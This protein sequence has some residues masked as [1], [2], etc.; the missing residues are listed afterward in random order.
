M[1]DLERETVRGVATC[2]RW[3]DGRKPLTRAEQGILA[4][5]LMGEH[6]SSIYNTCECLEIAGPV[7][8]LALERAIQIAL[9]ENETF[10]ARFVDVG[11]GARIWT[12]DEKQPHVECVDIA[13]GEDPWQYV[14]SRVE[15][16]LSSRVDLMENALPVQY[17]YRDGSGHVYWPINMHHIILDGYSYTLLTKRVAQ[18]YNYLV[19]GG[20]YPHNWT[21]TRDALYEE[22]QSY[23]DSE[24][25]AEDQCY[26]SAELSGIDEGAVSPKDDIG[27]ASAYSREL[28]SFEGEQAEL[29]QKISQQYGVSAIEALVAAVVYVVHQIEASRDT[30]IGV[31]T[32]GRAGSRA[33]RAYGTSSNVLPLRVR[34]DME[35]SVGGFL[36]KVREKIDGLRRHQRHRIEDVLMNLGIS[37]VDQ[38]LYRTTVNVVPFGH[39]IELAGCS[40]KVH[41]ISGG[42]SEALLCN[43]RKSADGFFV[44][45]D[46][47]E[48]R[49]AAKSFA[50]RLERVIAQFASC[51]PDEMLTK[52]S[53]LTRQEDEA[54][55]RPDVLADWDDESLTI[56]KAFENVVKERQD[57]VAVVDG[58]LSYTYLEIDERADRVARS[59]TEMGVRPGDLVG[60]ITER[61]A[62][63]VV[64]MLAIMKCSATYLPIDPRYPLTRV[65]DILDDAGSKA[66]V[67]DGV[68]HTRQLAEDAAARL[69]AS[70]VVDMSR[71]AQDRADVGLDG[72]SAARS[73]DIA[74]VLYTSG[75]TGKP[76]G[77]RITHKNV[78]SLL[79]SC[80]EVL[81]VGKDDV[82]TV[83]HSYSFDFSTWEIWGSL[84]TRGR[85]VVV[86]TGDSVDPNNFAQL[87]RREQ[88]TVLSQTPTA[89]SQLARA[90]SGADLRSVRVV[91]FGGEA[92]NP[93]ALTKAVSHLDGFDPV[94]ANMYGITETTVHTTLKVLRVNQLDGFAAH[95]NGSPIG[96]ELPGMGIFVLDGRR[97]PRPF[98][99]VGEFY[100]V[101]TGVADGYVNRAALTREKFLDL[102]VGGRTL[103]AYRTGDLGS[104]EA[105][106]ELYYYGRSDNQVKIRGHRIETAEVATA[107]M[108]HPDVREAWV[109]A[110][111]P[112]SEERG[113]TTVLVGYFISAR[114]G[115][116]TKEVL[117]FLAETLPAYMIPAFL[118]EIDGVPLTANNKLD[119]K[120]LPD[121]WATF[122]AGVTSSQGAVDREETD[123]WLRMLISNFEEVLHL[124]AGSVNA[125]GNFFEL[126]GHSILAATLL[127]RIRKSVEES[128]AQVSLGVS[129]IFRNPTPR[130]L[131]SRLRFAEI[132]ADALTRAEAKG[133]PD[134]TQ[135]GEAMKP[136]T[137]ALSFEQ[138]GMWFLHKSN[139]Q[140]TAY[141]IGFSVSLPEDVDAVLVA[142]ALQLTVDRHESLRTTYQ[143][144]SRGVWQRVH[145]PGERKVAVPVEDVSPDEFDSAVKKGLARTFDLRADLPIAARIVRALGR[146]QAF[147]FVIHHIAIDGWSLSLF[148][149]DLSLAY[150]KLRDGVEVDWPAVT[151]HYSDYC[152]LVN[153]ERRSLTLLGG[154]DDSPEKYWKER[155]RA[156]PAEVSTHGAEHRRGS[157]GGSNAAMLEQEMPS[158]VFD[159]VRDAARHSNVTEFSVLHAALALTLH[160]A[161]F[162]VDIVI[163]TPVSA[164]TSKELEATVGM[165]A[166]SVPLRTQIRSNFTLADFLHEVWDSDVA[167]IRYQE[168]PFAKIVD[169]INPPR[170]LG[171]HPIFQIMLSLQ[172][173]QPA[174]L[175]LGSRSHNLVPAMNKASKFDLFF[176]VVPPEG[177]E[178]GRVRVEFDTRL[179]GEEFVSTLLTRFFAALRV[180]RFSLGE[181][182]GAA[183]ERLATEFALPPCRERSAAEETRERISALNSVGECFARLMSDGPRPVVHAYY[184]PVREGAITAVSAVVAE[185]SGAY[186]IVP[187]AVSSIPRM[188][189]GEVDEAT[190]AAIAGD[191]ED[192]IRSW[193][194]ELRALPGVLAVSVDREYA[195]QVS[196]PLEIDMNEVAKRFIRIDSSETTGVGQDCG[197]AIAVSHGQK[198]GVETLEAWSDVLL[199]AISRNVEESIVHIDK[200]GVVVR[201]DY[202]ELLWEAKALLARLRDLGLAV[203]DKVVFQLDNS[204]QFIA[205]LWA[206]ILGGYIAVP[207]T[208]VNSFSAGRVAAK[209]L[210]VVLELLDFPVV[211]GGDAELGELSGMRDL[212]DKEL[213]RTVSIDELQCAPEAFCAQERAWHSPD[214]DDVFLMLMTSGS[215][216]RPKAVRLTHRNVLARSEGATVMN[217]LTAQDV[218]FNWIP[219]DH[220]TGVVMSHLRDVYLGC[221]QIHAATSW[222]LEDVL[223]WW[224]QVDRHDVTVTWAPNFAFGL[225]AERAAAIAD[226]PWDLRSVRHITNAGEMVVAEVVQAFLRALAPKGLAPDVVHPG[227]GMSETCSVVTDSV[228]RQE[229]HKP[230]DTCGSKDGFVSCGQPYPGFSMRVVDECNNVLPEGKEGRFQV[231]GAS[232]T[233]GYFNNDAANTSSFTA[234]GWFETG[235]LALIRNGELYLTGRVKDV[236][237]MNGVN[238]YSHEIE[239]CVEELPEVLRSYVAAFPVR[240]KNA[241]TDELAVALVAAGGDAARD[242]ALYQQVRNKIRDD[243]GVTPH[244]TFLVS[245]A[246]IPKTEIGK[247]QRSAL[248]KRLLNGDFDREIE[249]GKRALGLIAKF[250]NWFYAPTWHAKNAVPSSSPKSAVIICD[251][252][253]RSSDMA[254]SVQNNLVQ[255]GCSAVIVRLGDRWANDGEDDYA[256]NVEDQADYLAS[257]RD[258][259]ERR[260][261]IDS[262]VFLGGFGQSESVD[263]DDY[264]GQRQRVTLDSLFLLGKS[265]AAMRE[266]LPRT[267]LCLVSLGSQS[268]PKGGRAC[269]ITS[270][271]AALLRSVAS[272]ADHIAV[273]HLDLEFPEAET[274]VRELSFDEADMAVAYRAGRRHVF[275]LSN[276]VADSLDLGRSIA[277]N[278][279]H[280]VTGGLSGVGYEVCSRLLRGG[281]R[282]L[283]VLGRSEPGSPSWQEAADRSLASLTRRADVRYHSV[284][285]ADSASLSQ[286]V[287]EAAQAWREA[288]AH[289]WHLASSWESRPVA[290]HTLESWRASLRSKIHGALALRRVSDGSVPITFF[291]SVNGIYGGAGA[292]AY[293]AECAFVDAMA[294]SSGG[295]ARSIAW[296]AWHGVGRNGTRDELSLAERRGYVLLERDQA[297]DSLEISTF[298]PGSRLV[299]GIDGSSVYQNR[300]IARAPSRVD[301][302]TATVRMAEST[303]MRALVSEAQESAQRWR[304]GEQWTLQNAETG[305]ADHAD[306]QAGRPD[307]KLTEAMSSITEVWRQQLGIEYVDVD[308]NFFDMGA[309]SLT[310]SGALY[311]LRE[312][313]T[314]RLVMVDLFRFPNTR[315]LAAHVSDH[316]LVDQPTDNTAVDA[317][318]A[319]TGPEESIEED[320]AVLTAATRVEKRQRNRSRRI[321]RKRSAQ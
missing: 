253:Q 96:R 267:R 135:P 222:V 180:V 88:V 8:A 63:M 87:I 41:Y 219:L 185:L 295:L 164:R 93:K 311:L 309:N 291:S 133:E 130:G 212:F 95:K 84:L 24:R 288:P 237:I 27:A 298:L 170:R 257:L 193:T 293:A 300:M 202:A 280:V 75:S 265:V 240:G 13:P 161:G 149:R 28:V 143:E 320:V 223:R 43:I 132:P 62:D 304:I 46:E 277:A 229:D 312:R 151:F 49:V 29:L 12:G 228:F 18:L 234:D 263:D 262:I 254:L 77:A 154:T 48:E 266:E 248:A 128:G 178:M 90:A 152:A 35:D 225:V 171:V 34:V 136:M 301:R 197:D 120:K 239:R 11:D 208:V 145:P 319:E 80:G 220:V 112:P 40:T 31:T 247:I 115:L 192:Q 211:L 317:Q 60:L 232:V 318:G 89:F 61:G 33:L 155:L 82:W 131:R 101:G 269:P 242:S 174:V 204:K 23:E 273:V 196:S 306:G 85:L 244:Y 139:P 5:E 105:D 283:L 195:G 64:A 176:D 119:V 285:V 321:V 241:K 276:V 255:A 183:S 281:V 47:D 245:K 116:S 233:S 278:G 217:E 305:K 74:Y 97:K 264:Y 73:D 69:Q 156:I 17:L 98:G 206:C 292:S 7:D 134:R 14:K 214:P 6:T 313:L 187:C 137:P 140:E 157:D 22:E 25:R 261:Q 57:A 268:L 104:R 163:G 205:A 194:Q 227:W 231:R 201:S 108:R 122:G 117:D 238:Y 107:I 209:K 125:G 37:G 71:A 127:M 111:S 56:D 215:T 230:T 159:E 65:A 10:S 203:G 315:S 216:G 198:L 287:A 38:S 36:K 168:Y 138:L 68:A 303:D 86:S 296:S 72:Q 44:H 173:V 30:V 213:M 78:L 275:G 118:V 190:L 110:A 169:L 162:G 191:G 297:L 177:F 114:R 272:E 109:L 302:L 76:K 59:L 4:S 94:L 2:M 92:L 299:V 52:T 279:F 124:P 153:A 148:A 167:D 79:R 81:P 316:L 186:D 218:S 308:K 189:D 83:F 58:A 16:H 21:E 70:V 243:I 106:G 20:E 50:E 15:T 144:D 224:E 199:R 175:K 113:A 282:R 103:R 307:S 259:A 9:S 182:V 146:E 179:Y 142:E 221:R 294:Q 166:N 184:V 67:H 1:E 314:D 289:F 53:V 188:P 258:I 150:Q 260:G 252:S 121:P 19:M 54:L 249:A 91:V 207:M 3:Q 102:E 271:A 226:K 32:I 274:V 251:D 236:I 160:S 200:A 147:V 55:A 51:G 181:K 66:L 246:D 165:V 141:N 235:D 126:G 270:A 100:V 310:L 284:D 286:A 210:A 158:S 123:P 42:V 290:A 99:C 129:E 39:D 250:P 45:V 26:W 256:V 172:N